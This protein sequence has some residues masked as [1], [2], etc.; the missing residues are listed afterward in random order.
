MNLVHQI[1]SVFAGFTKEVERS[2]A[3]LRSCED[4]DLMV[5]FFGALTRRIFKVF[6][7]NA[8]YMDPFN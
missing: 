8:D 3:P 5:C 1:S 7:L 6:S 2:M 4:K